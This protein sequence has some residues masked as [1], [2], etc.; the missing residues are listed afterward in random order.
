MV[1]FIFH[2]HVCISLCVAFYI[3]LYSF[4]ATAELQVK[5]G[6]NWQSSTNAWTHERNE[7]E[8]HNPMDE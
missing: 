8:S 2:S 6:D 5:I 7:N 1:Q 3:G 4:G